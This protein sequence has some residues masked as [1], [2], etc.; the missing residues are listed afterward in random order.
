LADLHIV[1]WLARVVMLAGGKSD[2]TGIESLE[3]R[4]GGKAIGDKVKAFWTAWLD[5]PSF[6]RV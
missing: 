5:R 3:K 6:K 4:L 2:A 1:A